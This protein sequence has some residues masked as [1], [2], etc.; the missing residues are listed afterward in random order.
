MISD[1]FTRVTALVD[2][3]SGQEMGS[4]IRAASLFLVLAVV[5]TME[6]R[7][8]VVVAVLLGLEALVVVDVLALVVVGG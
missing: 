6:L 2:L 3:V 8:A 5:D 7:V 4:M 1:M